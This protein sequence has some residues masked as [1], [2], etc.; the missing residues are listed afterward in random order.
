[1]EWWRHVVC[2]L[3]GPALEILQLPEN[4][5]AGIKFSSLGDD[6][7][8]YKKRI[9]MNN[10]NQL[11]LKSFHSQAR[12][13]LAWHRLACQPEMWLS[14]Y[15]TLTR[16]GKSN[17]CWWIPG[18]GKAQPGDTLMIQL[19][20]TKHLSRPINSSFPCIQLLTCKK[21][22]IKAAWLQRKMKRCNLK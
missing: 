3:A 4:P 5:Q 8:Y 15:A 14:L 13:A 12:S 2:S 20:K 19:D 9:H 1:M 17:A 18:C 10:D 6:N 11:K 7:F 21:Y 22:C 16:K